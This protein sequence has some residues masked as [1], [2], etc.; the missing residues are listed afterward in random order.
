MNNTKQNDI[1][2]MKLLHY[3]IT[4]KN[5]NPVIVHG[6]QNEIWLENMDSDIKIVRIN[7][8]YIHN[9]EQL[10]YDSYKTS[11]L[12][13]QI[14]KK[15]FSFKIKT[16]MFYLDLN[17]NLKLESNNLN[18]LVNVKKESD[19]KN[20]KKVNLLFPDL[21][22]KLK[23]SEKGEDLYKKINNDI[24]KKNLEESKKMENLF[25]EKKPVI[26][27]V[28][29]AI[30]TLI[31]LFMYLFGKGS[32]D[33]TTLYNFGALVKNKEFF[34]I[35]T[36]I[37]IHI[38]FIHFIFNVYSLYILGK[39]V[40]NFFSHLKTLIIFLYSGI[41]GN[42]LSLVLMNKSTISAGASGAIFGLMGALLYFSHIQ[43]SYMANALRKQ[44]TPVIIINLIL[45]LYITSIN[46]YA[47]LGGFIGG[48]LISMVLGV[49]YKT[50]KTEKVNGLIT[51]LILLIGLFYLAYLK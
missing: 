6:I 36:S 49:K 26:T 18:T 41:I 9:Y 38:G 23:F 39:T 40:E 44:I 15:T 21:K 5:Y 3:F 30:M 29:I 11:K 51:S 14:K 20:D 34:R 19:I 50:T 47:H 42:L 31:M 22:S 1:I 45:S 33:V 24:I 2:A 32:L 13:N 8:N 12:I 10:K 27:Y 25:K 43:R 37:F 46:F 48:I 7:L 28:L 35:I 16:L 4:E 17:S